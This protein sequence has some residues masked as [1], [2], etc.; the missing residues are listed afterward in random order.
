MTG[1][2]EVR[3]YDPPEEEEAWTLAHALL[4][5]E[6][7]FV[8]FNR[9]LLPALERGALPSEGILNTLHSIGEECRHILYHIGDSMFFR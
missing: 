6:E 1:C 2:A 7:S 3:C 5:P 4:D 9:K 8:T